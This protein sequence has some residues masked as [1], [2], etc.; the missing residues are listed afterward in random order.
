MKFRYFSFRNIFIAAFVFFLP[1]EQGSILK[2]PSSCLSPK[3]VLKA[4][5]DFSWI[6]HCF[7]RLELESTFQAILH[8]L[9]R[10]E[11]GAGIVY[12]A[13][14]LI[15]VPFYERLGSIDVT[16]TNEGKQFFAELLSQ[17]E[18]RILEEAHLLT[19]ENSLPVHQ[20]R[21]PGLNVLPLG[22]LIRLNDQNRFYFLSFAE[23][24]L[25][26]KESLNARLEL[27]QDGERHFSRLLQQ[28]PWLYVKL[29]FPGWTHTKG[30]IGV[31]HRATPPQTSVMAHDKRY[32]WELLSVETLRKGYG[33]KLPEPFHPDEDCSVDFQESLITQKELFSGKRVLEIG[34][35][36]GVNILHALR[37]GARSVMGTERSWVSYFLANWNLVFSAETGQI[38]P[39]NLDKKVILKKADGFGGFG[40][41]DLYLFNT[42][43]VHSADTLPILTRPKLNISQGSIY[44][45][46]EDFLRL[47]EELANRLKWPGTRA[48]W[49]FMLSYDTGLVKVTAKDRELSVDFVTG[50]AK[51][52]TKIRAE[53]FLS[54]AGLSKELLI[55]PEGRLAPDVYLVFDPNAQTDLPQWPSFLEQS[56]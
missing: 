26:K 8:S 47:F 18:N 30:D 39:E 34:V 40:P 16:L 31:V 37:F 19:Y 48:I 13:S 42:P 10:R 51:S 36:S 56:L 38:D 45:S 11:K 12:H 17:N 35:G 22:L 6:Q 20:K 32:W 49:R 14:P 27:Y 44:I 29:M 3:T 52:K 4:K 33:E 24:L 54:R 25:N 23:M 1:F 9:V 15:P 21:Y 55:H 7:G 2:V 28:L 5:K 53:K 50:R 43:G 46:V 41:A